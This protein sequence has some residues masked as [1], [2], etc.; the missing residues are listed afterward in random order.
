MSESGILLAGNE[1]PNSAICGSLCS[2]SI[3]E[4]SIHVPCG[5]SPT[6]IHSRT[7]LGRCDNGFYRRVAQIGGDGHN[8][9]G[10]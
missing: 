1:T 6:P 3:T 4:I 5:P 9:G 8:I 10:G 2:L 7:N